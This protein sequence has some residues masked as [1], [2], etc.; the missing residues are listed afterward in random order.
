MKHEPQFRAPKHLSRA[1]R[2]WC[3]DVVATWELENHHWRLLVLAAEAW[4]RCTQ[5]RELIARE[6]L[7]IPTRDGGAKLHPA[8][9]VEDASRIAFARLLRELDLDVAPPADRKRPPM[10]RSVRGGSTHAA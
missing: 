1:I 10:L 8:C 7:T 9:R 5:A 3:N 4:D 6:G 2:R